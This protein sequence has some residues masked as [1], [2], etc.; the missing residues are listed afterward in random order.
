MLRVG[1]DAD[2]DWQ[3]LL[4]V[5]WS[6]TGTGAVALYLNDYSTLSYLLYWK[7]F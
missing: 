1:Y 5:V 7:I 2:V 6:G 3:L 4:H